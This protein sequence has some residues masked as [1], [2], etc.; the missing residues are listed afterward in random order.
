ML[1]RR[2]ARSRSRPPPL[3]APVAAASIALTAAWLALAVVPDRGS[4]QSAAASDSTAASD[5]TVGG[6]TGEVTGRVLSAHDRRP[7]E[8]AAVTAWN[9]GAIGASALTR[10]DGSYRLTGLPPGRHTVTISIPDHVPYDVD[11]RIR[12]GAALE[13]DVVLSIR[14]PVISPVHA[15]TRRITLRPVATEEEDGPSAGRPADTE[16]R[17]LESGPGGAFAARALAALDPDPPPSEP[18]AGLYVRGAASDLKRVYLDGAPV[19]APYHLGG[20][21]DALPPGVLGSA[22]LYGGGAPL[23]VDGGLSSVLDLRTRSGAGDGFSTGGHVDMLG[24]AVRMEGGD[25]RVAYLFSGRRAHTGGAEWLVGGELPYGYYDLLGRVDA[26]L[27]DGHRLAVTGFANEEGVRLGRLGTLSDRERRAHWGNEA[28]SL[29]YAAE[30]GSTR[31]L[32]TAATTRFST[33]LPLPSDSAETSP[34]AGTDLGRSETGRARVALDLVTRTGGLELA[35]GAA[36]DDHRLELELPE[37][38]ALGDAAG[39]RWA[40][41]GRS[42]A[43]YGAATVRPS[44]EV[45]V[46]GGLR[47]QLHGDG[48]GLRVAP[49]LAVAWEASETTDLEVS[50]GRFHQRLEAPESA[51]SGDLDTWSELLSRR[52]DGDAPAASDFPGLAVASASHLSVRLDHRPREGLTFGL[53]G[54]F[55]TF[56]DLAGS[57]LLSAGAPAASEGA[58]EGTEADAGDALGDLHSSGADLWIDWSSEGW[59]AWGGYS[60]AW[61]WSEAPPDSGGAEEDRFAGRQL[62]SAGVEAPLPGRVRLSGELKASTGLPFT[63]VPELATGETAG[64]APDGGGDATVAPDPEPGL[65]GTPDGSF[66]RLDLTLSRSWTVELAGRRTAIRPYLRFLNALDRRDGIF[67]HFD[68]SREAPSRPLDSMPMLPVVGVSWELF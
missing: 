68:P 39:A 31:A 52:T 59:R 8:G 38:P 12:S 26:R 23:A 43:A 41:L 29:R 5:T 15:I 22:R 27:A 53:E 61:T 18:A 35:Y 21:M 36:F 67:Y 48:H 62:V 54:Y 14:P 24:S 50:A 9:A 45:T 28:A 65:A 49:R 6:R 58:E 51:L 66:L 40:G 32:L 11:V 46:R 60:L 16:L 56:D 42:V 7:L 33:A 2:G 4:A 17:S 44:D 19:Y 57:G 37:S 13:L 47:G 55:K 34:V 30:L 63:R 3:G 10:A 1:S 64:A 25:Q 20:L